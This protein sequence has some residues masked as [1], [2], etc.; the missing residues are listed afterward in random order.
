MLVVCQSMTRSVTLHSKR[1]P[2]YLE[3]SFGSGQKEVLCDCS[4]PCLDIIN[5]KYKVQDVGIEIPVCGISMTFDDIN[6]IFY[7]C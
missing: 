5:N 7:S 1:L 2:P 3:A 6:L 4:G